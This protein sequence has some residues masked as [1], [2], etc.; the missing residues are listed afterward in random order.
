MKRTRLARTARLARHAELT[1]TTPL[2]THTPIRRVSAKRQAENRQRRKV[3]DAA[4]GDAPQCV[5]PGCNRYAD[6]VHEP[7][8]RGRGGSI[9]D[10]NNMAPLC[11]THHDEVQKGPGW[12]YDLGLMVHSWDG[13]ET[14]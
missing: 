8:T 14:A 10:P 1:S 2:V 13:G 4:F 5:R 12:A 3:M 11:R 7:L 9:T 6:D